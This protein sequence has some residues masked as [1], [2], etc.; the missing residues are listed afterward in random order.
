MGWAAELQPANEHVIVLV[1][2]TEPFTEADNM[3]VTRGSGGSTPICNNSSPSHVRILIYLHPPLLC[4][5]YDD[6]CGIEFFSTADLAR[7]LEAVDGGPHWYDLR[8]MTVL[9]QHAAFDCK[10]DDIIFLW[11]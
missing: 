3:P 10:I 5:L 1:T 9:Q 6:R 2:A 8:G 4:C 7:A 11:D